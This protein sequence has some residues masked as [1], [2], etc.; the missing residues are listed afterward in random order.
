MPGSFQA[1]L[2]TRPSR[3]FRLEGF[4]IFGGIM[5]YIWHLGLFIFGF[6]FLIKGADFFV[7]SSSSIA[8]KLKMSPLMIGMTLVAFGTSLPELAVSFISALTVEPGQTSDIALG[9]VVGSNIVNIT[10]ILGV[11]AIALPI[12]VSKKMNTKELPFL[13]G[14][15]IILLIFGLFFQSDNL[16]VWWEAIIFLLLFTVYMVVMIKTYQNSD[17]HNDIKVM[18]HKK[19][20]ILLLLGISMVSSGG[21]FV[22]LGATFLSTEFLVSVLGMD[23]I[24]A[25]TLVGLSI[26]AIGT[27]LPELVT[28]VVAAKKRENEIAYGNLVGSNIFNILFIL[29]L[30]GI[31]IPLGINQD[32]MMDMFILMFITILTIFI[33][34]TKQKITKI[35]G[36][37]LVISYLLYLTYIILRAFHL[38]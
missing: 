37:I 34:I 4:Y 18:S 11:T 1:K 8:R 30:T 29:G 6:I 35:E 2:V 26:V 38:L 5:D 10:L 31:V 28:S 12:V 36:Y 15:S 33:S 3:L 13:M 25:T 32:V 20:V 17:V 9:N 14:S 21:Y 7:T 22:T 27:S 24:K 23:F 19:S 16:I